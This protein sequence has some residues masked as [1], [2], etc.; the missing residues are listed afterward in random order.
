[1]QLFFRWHF[2][3]DIFNTSAQ[4]TSASACNAG[5]LDHSIAHVDSQREGPLVLGPYVS[6][7]TLNYCSAYTID[8]LFKHINVS[9]SDHS[10]SKD[11][12]SGIVNRDTHAVPSSSTSA[13]VTSAPA[14]SD[15]GCAHTNAY[16]D[17][18]SKGPHVFGP[19]ESTSI[20][21]CCSIYSY[22]SYRH[23]CSHVCSLQLVC[24]KT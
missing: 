3:Q 10:L 11:C 2:L 8:N 16:S 7:S 24:R 12:T 5:G 22:S 17:S 15:G 18:Q 9:A 23:D 20:L 4:F 6:T 1:M 19:F 21:D 13:Q 14:C